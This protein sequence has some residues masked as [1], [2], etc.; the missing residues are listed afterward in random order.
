MRLL[1]LVALLPLAASGQVT[2]DPLPVIYLPGGASAEEC[3]SQWRTV[4]AVQ[5]H[6]A[7]TSQSRVIRTIDAQRRVD[8]NDYSESLTAV[9]RPGL[10]RVAETIAFEA[11]GAGSGEVQDVEYA[12]GDEIDV[13]GNAGEGFVYFASG[14]S[15]YVGFI[16]GYYGGSEVEVVQEPVVEIWIYLVPRGDRPAAWLNTAQAGLVEREA[17]CGAR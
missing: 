10:V 9:L 17:F 14:P 11:V 2:V 7:P 12:P 16:P 15:V 4:A 13:L 3:Y 6:S 8:A 1:L 5:A